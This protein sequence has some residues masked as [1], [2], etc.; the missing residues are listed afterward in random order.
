[1]VK[2][3]PEA[4]ASATQG[5]GLCASRT[6]GLRPSRAAR[7][8]S[9]ARRRT[10]RLTALPT[11]W[12]TVRILAWRS[13]SEHWLLAGS[14]PQSTHLGRG[15]DSRA[16]MASGVPLIL[17]STQGLHALPGTG[18]QPI[19]ALVTRDRRL[20]GRRR[21]HGLPERTESAAE[22]RVCIKQTPTETLGP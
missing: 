22:G 6:P 9:A 11:C 2:L 20:A 18:R 7:N 14:H 16:P 5:A 8:R 3:Q 1:V 17:T 13:M 19:A 21:S 4:L 12:Q 15:K 10:L